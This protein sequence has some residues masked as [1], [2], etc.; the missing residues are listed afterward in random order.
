[1][2]FESEGV[3]QKVASHLQGLKPGGFGV[4]MNFRVFPSVAKIAFIGIKDNKPSLPY[5]PE[6]LWRFTVV[7]V[8]LGKPGAKII[9][10]VVDRV[11]EG[12]FEQFEF[13]G[14]AV[15]TED[16]YTCP[17]HNCRRCAGNRR[18]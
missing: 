7:F 8:D 3:T 9:M 6:S 15:S 16:G 13:G 10:L 1:M 17:C 18:R 5:E 14:R 2:S 4:V 12:E 11:I